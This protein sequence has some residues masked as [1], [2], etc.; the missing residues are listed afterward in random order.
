MQFSFE[1]RL[2]SGVGFERSLGDQAQDG[3]QFGQLCGLHFF[4]ESLVQIRE[5]RQVPLH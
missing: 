3:V 4:A 5:D 1:L 2:G